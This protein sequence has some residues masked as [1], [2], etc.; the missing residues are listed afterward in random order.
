M[1]FDSDNVTITSFSMCDDSL[2]VQRFDAERIEYTSVDT[3]SFQCVVGFQAFVESDTSSDQKTEIWS[4]FS[5]NLY[6]EK[7][8]SEKDF[9]NFKFYKLQYLEL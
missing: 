2:Y 1:I 6:S 7:P 9:T 4:C 3:F 8:G 5:D